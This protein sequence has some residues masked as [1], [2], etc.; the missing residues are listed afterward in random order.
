[1]SL[2]TPPPTASIALPTDETGRLFAPSAA[3]NAPHICK[4]LMSIAPTKG[5][6]M[7]IASGTGQHIITF[8]AAMPNIHWQP[9][10]VDATRRA[11]I[12]SYIDEAQAPNIA[13][14]IMLNATTAGWSEN[15]APVD[16]ITL[17]NLLHLISDNEAET[18]IHEASKTLLLAGKLFLYGPFKRD[19][20]LISEG[21]IEFD[22][23]IRAADPETGYKNDAWVKSTA[24]KDGLTFDQAIEMPANNL[25]LVFV[26]EV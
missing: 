21:D 19:G 17:A 23:N 3:R 22:S 15:I 25:A 16:L 11:S 7:E 5:T 1:M 8:A 26:Q 24:R 10:E 18:L 13:R 20:K 4:A 6:A 14:P 12:Q 9:T 2:R